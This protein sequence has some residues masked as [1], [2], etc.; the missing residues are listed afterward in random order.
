MRGIT[1]A[2]EYVEERKIQKIGGSN[3]I[4]LPSHWVKAHNLKKGSMVKIVYNGVL[5]ILP[6]EEKPS[7]ELIEAERLHIEVKENSVVYTLGEQKK[8]SK[9]PVLQN[10]MRK[11][12]PN[13]T[14]DWLENGLKK[15]YPFDVVEA[16]REKL[17][18]VLKSLGGN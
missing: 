2:T 15:H 5:K 6:L 12:G 16:S 4:S 9:I 14:L 11:H 3:Q 10:A 18:R 1:I 13:K 7:M 17:K 8:S